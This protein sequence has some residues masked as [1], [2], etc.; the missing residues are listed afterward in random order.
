MSVLAWIA[1]AL[2]AIPAAY[3]LLCAAFLLYVRLP[4]DPPF[5]VVED[6]FL[7]VATPFIA[8]LVGIALLRRG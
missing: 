2:V 6:V 8:C 1:V 4:D 7:L 5:V 3:A